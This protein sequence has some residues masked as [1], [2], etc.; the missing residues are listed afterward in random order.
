MEIGL[1]GGLYPEGGFA[2][3]WR[4]PILAYVYG[5][6]ELGDLIARFLPSHV[7]CTSY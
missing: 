3:H 6:G 5:R 2:L 7:L 4:L 1:I